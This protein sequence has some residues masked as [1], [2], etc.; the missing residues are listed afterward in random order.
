[1]G[2]TQ[3]CPDDLTKGAD[4]V[5]D[6][7][8]VDWYIRIM[9]DEL[10]NPAVE[11]LVPIGDAGLSAGT[12]ERTQPVTVSCAGVDVPYDGYYDPSGNNIAWPLGV[13]LF[14]QPKD[15]A[16][17]ATG[18]ECEV[19]IKPD[20]IA[21]KDGEHVPTAQLGPYKFKIAPMTFAAATPAAPK[22]PAKPVT[23]KPTDPVV[24]TF[25]AFVD[26]LSLDPTEV[27]ILEVT[28]CTDTTGIPHVAVI[29]QDPKDPVSLHIGTI[30]TPPGTETTP[31]EAFLH[32]KTYTI[33]FNDGASVTDLAGGAAELPGA[34]DLTLCFKTAE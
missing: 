15:T 13:S 9:F 12:L 34:A 20:V 23:I 27:T 33:T 7:V 1:V 17:I 30:D 6:T 32:G 8:P 10:L 22:D 14:I 2:P 26:E 4:E 25:N 18:T 5:T 31:K 29:S 28:A 21:D 3:I 16:A 19:S 24:I 11:D